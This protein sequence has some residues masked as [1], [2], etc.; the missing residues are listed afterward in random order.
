GFYG[1]KTLA[2]VLLFER[3]TSFIRFTS[4]TQACSVCDREDADQT[5]LPTGPPFAVT[6][7]ESPGASEV[8]V[9]SDQVTSVPSMANA[10]PMITPGG[11]A[12]VP[13]FVTFAENVVGFVAE[14]FIGA[15]WM[16]VTV[17]SMPTLSGTMS[18]LLFSSISAIRF[19]SSTQ[20]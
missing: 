3:F 17:R 9:L 12:T 8:V 15:Q 4:S 14:R 11:V 13:T 2:N 6:V 5:L 10:T 19:T 20:A 18:L 7:T 1:T 16:S